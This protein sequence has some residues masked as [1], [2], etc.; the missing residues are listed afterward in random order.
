MALIRM[1]RF[2]R[3]YLA[4][5]TLATP[6]KWLVEWF[7]GPTSATGL[8]VDEETAKTLTAVFAATQFIAESIS[9][10]PCQLYRYRRDG[11]GKDRAREHPLY[12]LLRWQ[13]NPW[14]T[15]MEF[16]EMLLG[17]AVLRGHCFAQIVETRGGAIEALIP[18]HPA[19]L[20][21]VS[22]GD[23]DFGFVYRYTSRSGGSREFLPTQLFRVLFHSPDGVFGTSRISLA[24]EAV[25]LGL[26][27]ERYAGKFFA[28][29][30]APGG[31]LQHPGRL[32]KEAHARLRAEWAARHESVENAQR[33]AILEEDMKWVTVGIAQK[34]AQFLESRKFQVTEIARLFRVPP[35]LQ[36]SRGHA[37]SEMA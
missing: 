1:P 30:G 2:L 27:A 10:M 29:N 18:L 28:N 24:R 17:H 33:T 5:T 19:R 36:W 35:Q 3:R 25:A 23:S 15:A 34:D 14:Q 4:S 6:E 22:T 26:A 20:Q 12:R 31:I 16:W 13:P 21:W 11:R 32:S 8:F 9:T 37:P 7:R